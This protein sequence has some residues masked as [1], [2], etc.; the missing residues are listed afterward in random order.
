MSVVQ[1]IKYLNRRKERELAEYMAA[2]PNED[3]LLAEWQD[4]TDLEN[5][6]FVYQI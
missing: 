3:K 5:P 2:N 4:E 6:R 1:Y